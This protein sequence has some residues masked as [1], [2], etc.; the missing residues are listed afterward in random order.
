MSFDRAQLLN[1]LRPRRPQLVDVALL[2]AVGLGLWPALTLAQ[3]ESPV[4]TDTV[5][6]V[7]VVVAVRGALEEFLFRGL[8][9]GALETALHPRWAVLLSAALFAA[10]H[11]TVVVAAYAF[12]V[13]LAFAVV[14]HHRQSVVETALAQADLETLAR[15]GGGW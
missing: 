11:P 10:F 3:A 1:R 5:H 9:Q 7:T 14:A 13:G 2:V 4:A 15:K 6:L 8:V 12:I